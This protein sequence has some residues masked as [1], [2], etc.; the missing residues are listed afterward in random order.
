LT[1]V[2]A[3]EY[4]RRTRGAPAALLPATPNVKEA[5]PMA[6]AKIGLTVEPFE[7]GKVAYAKLAPITAKAKARGRVFLRLDITN[8]ERSKVTVSSVTVSFPG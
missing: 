4:G 7:S 6:A 1:A 3:R 8:K 5:K 2:A